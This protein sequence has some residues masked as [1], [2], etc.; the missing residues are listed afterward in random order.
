MT[1]F[2]A[3]MMTLMWAQMCA[4]CGHTGPA[5]ASGRLSEARW[6]DV[7]RMLTRICAHFMAQ[8]MTTAKHRSWH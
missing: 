1:H 3:L 4:E 2:C 7:C 6:Q 8:M 5:G